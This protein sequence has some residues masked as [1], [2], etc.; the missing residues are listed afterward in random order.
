M[1]KE[2]IPQ[3]TEGSISTKASIHHYIHAGRAMVEDSDNRC[4]IN[5]YASPR[6]PPAGQSR[7]W[8]GIHELVRKHTIDP[9]I[10]PGL[11][12]R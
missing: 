4:V 1:G 2:R 8:V 12:L 11:P 3:Y 5:E 6:I 10:V 9:V 7:R